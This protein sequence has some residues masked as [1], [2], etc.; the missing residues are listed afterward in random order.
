MSFKKK[1]KKKKKVLG[2]AFY[3]QKRKRFWWCLKCF[4]GSSKAL[5]LKGLFRIDK[6]K[7]SSKAEPDVS[8][9]M[10]A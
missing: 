6:S 3:F 7:T 10:D 1:K 5:V 8:T 4:W 9:R 2:L